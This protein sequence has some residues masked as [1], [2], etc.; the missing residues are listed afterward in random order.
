MAR[1]LPILSTDRIYIFDPPKGLRHN[2][3]VFITSEALMLGV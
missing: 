1:K 3:Y 2:I